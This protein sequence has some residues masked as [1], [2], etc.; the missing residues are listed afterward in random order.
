MEV[1]G[2]G[3]EPPRL[4]IRIQPALIRDGLVAKGAIWH[5]YGLRRDYTLLE[6][7]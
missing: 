6:P 1:E 5:K 4:K 3:G 7:Y 2:G